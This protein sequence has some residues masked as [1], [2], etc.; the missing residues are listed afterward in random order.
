MIIKAR[1]EF[2]PYRDDV[3]RVKIDI[4]VTLAEELDE[5]MIKQGDQLWCL[6]GGSSWEVEEWE[7][8]TRLHQIASLDDKVLPNLHIIAFRA[9][10]D[11]VPRP[12]EKALLL[13]P[14][15]LIRGEEKNFA[16]IT[17][18]HILIMTFASFVCEDCEPR[19]ILKL[20]V[21]A[22]EDVRAEFDARLKVAE[23]KRTCIEYAIELLKSEGF[24]FDCR[25]SEW[26]IRPCNRGT[27]NRFGYATYLEFA[28][29]HSLD[30]RI[31][32]LYIFSSGPR[33]SLPPSSVPFP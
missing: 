33:Q 9:T 24:S 18:L 22:P 29:H 21:D 28:V 15:R 7:G 3:V 8:V 27:V 12:Q 30:P 31:V 5:E 14:S 2:W 19:R 10:L 26:Y 11:A 6:L 16:G 23:A 25:A 4:H 13:S 20:N 17:P 32:K 1:F